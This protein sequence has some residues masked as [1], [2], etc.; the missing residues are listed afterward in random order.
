M[1]KQMTLDEL[2]EIVGNN[3]DPVV[4]L[5]GRREIPDEYIVKARQVGNRLTRL[6]P[7]LRFRSGNAT[8][9]DEAFASGV[10]EVDAGRLQI[11]APY[12]THREK[13]RL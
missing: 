13:S 8:G 4:L 6:F 10:A 12:K 3:P 1:R 11:V 7:A 2:A 9:T 5:E